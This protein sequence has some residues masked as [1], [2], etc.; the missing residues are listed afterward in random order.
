MSAEQAEQESHE[1]NWT[2]RGVRATRTCACGETEMRDVFGK[3][4]RYVAADPLNAYERREK[5]LRGELAAVNRNTRYGF[6]PV[7]FTNSWVPIEDAS[8]CALKEPHEGD[9][10][11]CDMCAAHDFLMAARGELARKDE[12]L[13]AAEPFSLLALEALDY[14][15]RLRGFSNEDDDFWEAYEASFVAALA[16]A[17][18]AHEEPA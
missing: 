18:L 6:C 8:E 4:W 11:R 10:I 7:C 16:R 2:S 17:A 15:E 1:H 13:R 14:Y 12:A 3:W 5:E 9:H